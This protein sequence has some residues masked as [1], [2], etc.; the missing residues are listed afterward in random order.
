M[1]RINLP[2]YLTYAMF[3]QTAAKGHGRL[4]EKTYLNEDV[5]DWCRTNLTK[6]WYWYTE[7]YFH[8]FIEFAN[9]EDM[10]LF[11]LKWMSNA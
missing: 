4:I 9:A 5:E 7:G 6:G 10:I 2:S 3:V 8:D 1:F 11:K